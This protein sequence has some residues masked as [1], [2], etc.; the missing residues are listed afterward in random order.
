MSFAD[1]IF[2]PTPGQTIFA[3]TVDKQTYTSLTNPSK[4]NPLIDIGKTPYAT[5]T[6]N[7]Q[8]NMTVQMATNKD[9]YIS[10]QVNVTN[11]SSVTQFYQVAVGIGIS[12]Q[13]INSDFQNDLTVT[14]SGGGPISLSPTYDGTT[15]STGIQRELLSTDGGVTFNPANEFGPLGSAITSAGT[16]SYSFSQDSCD[17]TTPLPPPPETF[18]YL[19]LLVGFNLSAGTTATLNGSESLAVCP[20]PSTLIMGFLAVIMLVVFNVR[21][22]HTRR[23]SNVR[24]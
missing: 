23:S 15:P 18:N 8:S 6:Y 13:S 5:F 4:F 16:T 3:I 22:H 10:Y 7:I 20:E 19:E 2:P 21:S 24:A 17:S 1:I 9:P 11:N 14:T 12:D